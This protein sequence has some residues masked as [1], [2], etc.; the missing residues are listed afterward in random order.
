[1]YT[2][3]VKNMLGHKRFWSSKLTQIG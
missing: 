2:G 3:L 1:V